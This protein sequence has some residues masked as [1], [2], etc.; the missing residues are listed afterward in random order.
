M[1]SDLKVDEQKLKAEHDAAMARLPELD[2]DRLEQI[3]DI[4]SDIEF[5]ITFAA[6]REK[7]GGPDSLVWCCTHSSF[8][9]GNTW[10]KETSTFFI[11]ANAP[12]YQLVV[13][14]QDFPAGQ[15]P[16]NVI[17]ARLCYNSPLGGWRF[18]AQSLHEMVQVGEPETPSQSQTKPKSE[19]NHNFK[20]SAGYVPDSQTAIALA[21]AIWTP[22]YGDGEI[23]KQKPYKAELREGTWYVSGSLKK[24]WHGGVAEAEIRKDDARV[25]RVTH[26]K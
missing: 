19:S 24:G 3:V 1:V 11:A 25:I 6:L 20:P 14:Y 23:K 26:G 22:I 16:T 12:D 9:K 21:V 4:L 5:P 15:R 18:V 7:L 8:K 10:A 13:D 17:R 2:G